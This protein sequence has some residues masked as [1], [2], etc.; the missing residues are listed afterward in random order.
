ML[1]ICML[2]CLYATFHTD[3]KTKASTSVALNKHFK[4]L[5]PMYLNMPSWVKINQGRNI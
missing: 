4:M 1:I 2:S 5:K 3:I